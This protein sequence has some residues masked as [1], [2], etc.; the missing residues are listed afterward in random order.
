VYNIT[1]SKA[2][3]QWISEKKQKSLKKDEEYR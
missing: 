2:L 1:S 3:P